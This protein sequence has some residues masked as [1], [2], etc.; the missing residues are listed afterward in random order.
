MV[1][2]AEFEESVAGKVEEATSRC[3]ELGSEER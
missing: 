2:R 3:T 1:G